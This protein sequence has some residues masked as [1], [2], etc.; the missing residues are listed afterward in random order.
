[1]ISCFCDFIC[2]YFGQTAKIEAQNGQK[3]HYIRV[4]LA[5]THNILYNIVV[6]M[7]KNGVKAT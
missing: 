3:P 4:F 6:K 1:M 7:A 2:L 5:I